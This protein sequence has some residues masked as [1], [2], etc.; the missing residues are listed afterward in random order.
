M[1]QICIHHHKRCLIRK[2]ARR[3]TVPGESNLLDSCV[4]C[5]VHPGWH[6]AL[7]PACD[8]SLCVSLPIL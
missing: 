3:P 4:D 5:K 7:T 2:N 1:P 8:R 6:T